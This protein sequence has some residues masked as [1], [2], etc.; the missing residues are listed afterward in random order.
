[1]LLSTFNDNIPEY[2]RAQGKIYELSSVL[3]IVCIAILAGAKEYTDI[4]SYIE[5]N[6]KLLKKLLRL[7]W[8]TAPSYAT[9]R[10]ICIHSSTAKLEKSF[11]QHSSEMRISS[12][13]GNQMVIAIDGKVLRNSY[14]NSNKVTPIQLISAFLV[15]HQLVIAHKEILND[16]KTN[17][18]PKVQELIKEL[19]VKGHV[20]TMDAMHCQKKTLEKIAKS[21][22]QAVLQVKANQ[23]KL[24]KSCQKLSN[25]WGAMDEHLEKTVGRNR[26]EKRRALVFETN[27]YFDTRVNTEWNKYVR[28]V[29]KV[30]R[31]VKTFDT[32]KQRWRSS[33]EESYYVATRKYD[34]KTVSEIVRSHWGIENRLHHVRDR[35]MKED[36]CRSWVGA[37]NLARLRS[38]ALNI[39]RFNGVTNIKKELFRNGQNIQRIIDYKG[40]LF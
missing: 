25:C 30:E 17:E 2:R 9:T 5:E 27:E 14:N 37:E 6:F 38:F 33:Y 11:R 26:I 31:S 8:R 18:I 36:E 19:N 35:S 24:H 29:I 16:D 34:A 12:G 3:T 39:M 15:G 22:N 40:L 1:M 10:R 23:S 28:C 7:R 32:E 21:G 13:G 20:F 4:S